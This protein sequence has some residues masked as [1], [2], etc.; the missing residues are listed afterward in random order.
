MHLHQV[1]DVLLMS[2]IVIKFRQVQ[3][4]PVPRRHDVDKFLV[5]N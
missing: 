2:A 3:G 1:I 4:L 5:K